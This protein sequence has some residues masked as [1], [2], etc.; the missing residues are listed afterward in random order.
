MKTTTINEDV[1]EDNEEISQQDLLQLLT[2]AAVFSLSGKTQQRI[3]NRQLH[4][5]ILLQKS[6]VFLIANVISKRKKTVMRPGK[7]QA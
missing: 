7:Y 2:Y 4:L 6:V 1:N 5:S 3:T